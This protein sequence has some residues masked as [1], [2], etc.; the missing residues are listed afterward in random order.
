MLFEIVTS[1][2]SLFVVIGLMAAAFYVMLL[3]MVKITS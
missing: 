1:V 3:Q 2:A